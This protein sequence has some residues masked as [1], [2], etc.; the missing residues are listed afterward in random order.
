[1]AWSEEWMW[2][3][4]SMLAFLVSGLLPMLLMV[5]LYSKVVKTLWFKRNENDELSYR[6]KVCL[7]LEMEGGGGEGA[8]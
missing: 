3:A 1:M 4:F 7:C 5:A 2:K 8:H 6:Q